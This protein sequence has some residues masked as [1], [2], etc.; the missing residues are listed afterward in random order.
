M[1]MNQWYQ[2]MVPMN[3]L[4][5]LLEALFFLPSCPQLFLISIYIF[6]FI[7]GDIVQEIFTIT[8][9]TVNGLVE[10]D[11]VN[12]TILNSETVVY[13]AYIIDRIVLKCRIA[14]P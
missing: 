6:L 10:A 9:S 11:T 2:K 12:I 7:T 13:C 3:Q 4:I 5:F 8:V 14:F 1:T